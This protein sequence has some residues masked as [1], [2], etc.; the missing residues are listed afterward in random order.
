M[1]NELIDRMTLDDL[2]GNARD[3]AQTIGLE[4]FIR[5]VKIYGGS[6]N[7]YVPKAE[8]LV[9]PIRDRLI[10]Q[11]FN[12]VNAG[13]LARKWGLTDRYIREIVREEKKRLRAAPAP[14]QL[15]LWE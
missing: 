10:L 9:K 12:G 15:S 8:E 1:R 14:V 13:R 5:L 4:A 11:E 7:L 6:S 2:T 3:L